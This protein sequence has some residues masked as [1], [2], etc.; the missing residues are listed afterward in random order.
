M[1]SFAVEDIAKIFLSDGGAPQASGAQGNFPPFRPSRWACKHSEVDDDDEYVSRSVSRL[2]DCLIEV[3]CYVSSRRSVHLRWYWLWCY[4]LRSCTRR[5]LIT[6]LNDILCI[7]RWFASAAAAAAACNEWW[8]ILMNLVVWM[9]IRRTRWLWWFNCKKYAS[10]VPTILL[11][12]CSRVFAVESESVTAV[13]RQL[14]IPNFNLWRFELKIGT[15]VTPALRNVCT[16][17]CRIVWPHNNCFWVIWDFCN[18]HYGK[19]WAVEQK[20]RVA[21]IAAVPA[22]AAAV[23]VGFPNAL[24]NVGMYPVY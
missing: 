23:A 4:R 1:I 3:L 2:V 7:A 20:L 21:V 11:Q 9:T 13:Q 14:S 22:V 16:T 15:L 19:N 8:M 18:L 24:L 10:P 6:P 17:C 5:M 12:W